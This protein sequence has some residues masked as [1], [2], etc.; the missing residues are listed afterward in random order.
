MDTFLHIISL[1]PSLEGVCGCVF[2]FP[3]IMFYL[4]YT[5]SFTIYTSY[6]IHM[7]QFMNYIA[8]LCDH[9]EKT[10]L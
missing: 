9:I 3:Y 5:L 4:L 1:S 6:L 7:T 10:F 2:L 8:I